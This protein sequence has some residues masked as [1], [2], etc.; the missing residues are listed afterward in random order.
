[1]LK[2][3]LLEAIFKEKP[4]VHPNLH[5]LLTSHGFAITEYRKGN[6]QYH[7]QQNGKPLVIEH[8]KASNTYMAYDSDKNKFPEKIQ[9]RYDP[10]KDNTSFEKSIKNYANDA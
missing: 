3:S 10:S 6:T 9:F 5:K 2:E 4:D 8:N 7:H 1:M